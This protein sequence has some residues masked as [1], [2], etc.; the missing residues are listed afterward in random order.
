ML[1][2]RDEPRAYFMK[3][4]KSKTTKRKP[5]TRVGSGTSLVIPAA[6]I[7]SGDASVKMWEGING[8]KTVSDLRMAL[9]VVCCRLQELE[10]KVVA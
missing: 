8:A 10:E 1:S 7:F 2:S 3:R 4:R 6:R 9:Y 5:V